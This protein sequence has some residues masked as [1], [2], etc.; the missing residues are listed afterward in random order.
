MMTK[1][2]RRMMTAVVRGQ[3]GGILMS[4]INLMLSWLMLMMLKR[5]SQIF[6]IQGG[7]K[8][9][10]NLKTVKSVVSISTK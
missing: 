6:M 1:M 3:G 5:I 7:Y 4:S 9:K 2:R 8:K 10:R